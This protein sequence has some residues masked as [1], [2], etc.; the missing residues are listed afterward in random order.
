MHRNV[1]YAVVLVI[2][3][4][5]IA[6]AVDPLGASRNEQ[7]LT[8]HDATVEAAFDAIDRDPRNHDLAVRE[9]D[10]VLAFLAA[11]PAPSDLERL[12]ELTVAEWTARRTVEAQFARVVEMG[13]KQ[14]PAEERAKLRPLLDALRQASD[15]M[16]QEYA[17]VQP[18]GR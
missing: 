2:A 15:A 9:T 3:L 7:W 12:H 13:G 16:L 17:R 5:V 4:A 8:K 14:A 11:N 6:V 10:R 1:A 18:P